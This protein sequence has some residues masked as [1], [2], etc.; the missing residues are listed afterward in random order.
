M[1]LVWFLLLLNAGPVCAQLP[2]ALQRADSA[3][4][5]PVETEMRNVH[6]RISPNVVLQIAYLRG[7]LIPTGTAP[8]WFE[9]PSSFTL[10]IDSAEVTIT[11]QSL[12]ALLNEYTFHYDGSP[13]KRL[14]VRF[15]G[16]GIEMS[17]TLDKTINL[18]FHIRA[19][20]RVTPDG[21]LL[22]RPTEVRVAGIGVRG[23]MG[24]FS[25]ELDDMVRVRRGRGITVQGNNFILE[26]AGLLPP[27]H[28]RGRLKSVRIQG[29]AIVQ[30]FVDPSRRGRANALA[31]PGEA[32]A[33]YML[34]RGNVLRFGK[35]TMQAADLM[36]IDA[37]PGDPFDVF[38][39]RLNDQLVAGTTRNE[40]DFGLVSRWPDYP[41]LPRT[42]NR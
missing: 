7:A 16:N 35:L 38:L 18:P 40:P 5:G 12:E 13:L 19:A 11:A 2:A 24:T 25:V 8:P 29:N 36:V 26:P 41:D 4:S 37:D 33:N 9:D 42:R 15:Q 28:I 20:L 31:R 30:T 6:F 21:R 34:Y 27:P 32:P 1:R 39:A 22:L 3:R 14:A 17:G 10:A 23:L